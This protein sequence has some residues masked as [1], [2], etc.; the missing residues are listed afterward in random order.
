VI[1]SVG[2]R[3]RSLQIQLQAP[4]QVGG[5]KVISSLPYT[6]LPSIKKYHVS[7]CLPLR[8]Q[9]HHPW[10]SAS[11]SH[12]PL[13]ESLNHILSSWSSTSASDDDGTDWLRRC[14]PGCDAA[15]TTTLSLDLRLL[16]SLPAL[17]VARPHPLL[18]ILLHV[19]LRRR[20]SRLPVV[21]PPGC[22]VAIMALDLWTSQL[23]PI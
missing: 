8:H 6:S 1:F 7:L 12:R 17:Q 18:L 19:C 23:V 20:Q 10:I 21:L 22:G 4:H 2:S 11:S 16:L 14:R 15:F 3:M 13:Y 9:Q 5:F